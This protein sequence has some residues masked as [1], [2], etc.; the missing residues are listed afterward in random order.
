MS[1]PVKKS[2]RLSRTCAVG[3]APHSNA[4]KSFGTEA[5]I[6]VGIH[7]SSSVPDR[8][9]FQIVLEHRRS[10]HDDAPTLGVDPSCDDSRAQACGGSLGNYSAT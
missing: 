9:R 6:W 7:H 3:T 4:S 5:A 2:L 8:R 10:A 1:W